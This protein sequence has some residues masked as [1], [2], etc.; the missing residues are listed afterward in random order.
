VQV[1]ARLI[2]DLLVAS[3]M[4][5]DKVRLEMGQVDLPAVIDAAVESLRPSIAEKGITLLKLLQPVDPVRGDPTRLQQVICNL[6]T[7]A[8][9]FTPGGGQVEIALRV[10]RGRAVMSVR[11]TGA[12]IS[13][14]FLP[15]VFDRFRQAPSAA[16][17]HGGLG[18]GLAIARHLVELHGGEIT[19]ASE[20]E[21]RGATFTVR[22]PIADQSS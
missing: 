10:S 12:G 16:R 2:E 3:R 5:S 9:K 1:Q 13:P 22:L 17:E 14:Q 4:A 20:G 8:I 21:G 6:L 11:D 19:A 7:N 18:L 15:H